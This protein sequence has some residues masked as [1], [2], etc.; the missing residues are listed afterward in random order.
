MFSAIGHPVLELQRVSFGPVILGD[1]SKA[2][3]RYLTPQEVSALK[4]AVDLEE[5]K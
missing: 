1:L 2:S 5:A 3:W 4:A